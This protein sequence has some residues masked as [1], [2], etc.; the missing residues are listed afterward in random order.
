MLLVVVILERVVH[1]I[2]FGELG[3]VVDYTRIG[4]FV[5]TLSRVEIFLSNTNTY[6]CGG[7]Y[8]QICE[9]TYVIFL[10]LVFTSSIINKH[11]VQQG[12]IFF[13]NFSDF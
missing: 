11:G 8:P 4:K 1:V 3:F 5:K 2:W 12:C 9:Y 10:D 6:T 13:V 7:S